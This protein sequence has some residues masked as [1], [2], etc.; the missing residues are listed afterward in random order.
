[1]V[2]VFVLQ[3]LM[4]GGGRKKQGSLDVKKK[5]RAGIFRG[6]NISEGV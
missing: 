6:E 2:V 3:Q 4:R 1:M 5:R